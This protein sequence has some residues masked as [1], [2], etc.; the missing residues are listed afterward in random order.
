MNIDLILTF[1]FTISS[2]ALLWGIRYR[3]ITLIQA[4]IAL[5]LVVFIG[6]GLREYLVSNNWGIF[7][8]MGSTYFFIWGIPTL[9]IGYVLD[10]KFSKD[11]KGC[12]IMKK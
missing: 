10:K 12:E 6:G 2:L 11:N 5:F 3:R 8:C 1:L 7:A 4:V 9:V